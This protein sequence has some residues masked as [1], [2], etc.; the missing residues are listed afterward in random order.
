MAVK[1]IIV[2]RT[3]LNMRKGKQIAQGAHASLKVFLDRQVMANS[4][5]LSVP[6]DQAMEQWV[7]GVFTKI[8]VQVGSEEELVRVYEAALKA[9][10]PAALITDM[11]ATEFHGVPTMTCC[12]I[13]PCE[14]DLLQPITG[15]LKLL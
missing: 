14:A 7:N 10:I 3:D 12:A 6:L 9:G 15:S 4:G 5:F 13:G 2:M 8:C 1:Q 11:G